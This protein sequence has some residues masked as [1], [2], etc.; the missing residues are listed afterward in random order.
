MQQKFVDRIE[1]IMLFCSNSKMNDVRRGYF[2][3]TPKIHIFFKINRLI[4][5]YPYNELNLTLLNIPTG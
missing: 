2:T 3:F 4:L 1:Y 5:S